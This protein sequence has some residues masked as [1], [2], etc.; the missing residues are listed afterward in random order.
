MLSIIWHRYLNH[1][2][3][4]AYVMWTD[5]HSSMFTVTN[6][7]RQGAVSSAIL[8]A[9]YIDELL[10]LLRQAKIGCHINGVF[11]GAVVFA[12]DILLL[13]ASCSGLQAMVD[14]CH[15]FAAQKNLKFGTNSDPDKSKTK[16][17]VFIRKSK[18]HLQLQPVLM[19]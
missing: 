14:I 11:Y 7:V 1:G 17:L 9:V 12:D 13:S 15:E 16:C 10:G 3:A 5:Q 2:R 8:F 4:S 6:G 19:S 18:A